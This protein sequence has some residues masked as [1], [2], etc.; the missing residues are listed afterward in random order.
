MTH[1][2][3]TLSR[4]VALHPPDLIIDGLIQP[5]PLELIFQYTR[6]PPPTASSRSG[7]PRWLFGVEHS[8]LGA[9]F[10]SM[11]RHD[12]LFLVLPVVE[13]YHIPIFPHSQVDVCLD[14]TSTTLHILHA[15]IL[16]PLSYL[17]CIPLLKSL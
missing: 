8:K 14:S 17:S 7:S 16:L 15:S 3:L 12:M 6:P 9:V 1:G 4:K 5:P 13:D 10:E 2:S 11:K